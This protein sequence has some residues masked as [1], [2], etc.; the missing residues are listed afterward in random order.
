MTVTDT[1]RLHLLAA[2]GEAF[3]AVESSDGVLTAI[4][5]ILAEHFGDGCG[6]YYNVGEAEAAGG[7]HHDATLSPFVHAA[8]G[9]RGRAGYDGL[10]GRVMRTGTPIRLARTTPE[11]ARAF[12]AP[13]AFPALVRHGFHSALLVPMRVPGRTIGVL[14][15]LRD[16]TP[17]GYTAAEQALLQ[18]LADY[19]ASS[20]VTTSLVKLTRHA[21]WLAERDRLHR[22][23]I[24]SVSHDLRTPLAAVQIAL[25][26]LD[27]ATAGQLGPDAVE[28]LGAARRGTQRLVI[29][30]ED[31]LAMNQ[32]DAGVLELSM[33]PLDLRTIV[34]EAAQTVQPLLQEKRQE[35]ELAFSVPLPAHGDARRLEHVITNILANVHR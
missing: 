12:I 28:L 19:I 11:E 8:L 24:A 16:R 31:L 10:S 23:A 17:A 5:R 26:L 7:W 13:Q 29:M 9:A 18:E 33:R 14:T 15:A 20:V 30:I 34:A 32:L 6:A 25:G 21:E 2:I 4:A 22:E 27:G 3:V 1:S 35:L